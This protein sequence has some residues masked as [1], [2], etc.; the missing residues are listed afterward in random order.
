MFSRSF[1]DQMM[2]GVMDDADDDGDDSA[3]LLQA[4]TASKRRCTVQ[5]GRGDLTARR[6]TMSRLSLAPAERV[7]SR[8]VRQRKPRPSLLP[9]QPK[10][11]PAAA[12]V[13]AP[14][15]SS[16][17]APAP[18]TKKN[19]SP[20][21]ARPLEDDST[22]PGGPQV[23]EDTAE[24]AAGSMTAPTEPAS[25]S[26]AAAA[27]PPPV[28]AAPA[29]VSVSSESIDLLSLATNAVPD[30]GVEWD[31]LVNS[32]GIMDKDT[33]A[34]QLLRSGKIDIWVSKARQQRSAFVEKVSEAQ[35]KVDAQWRKVESM[36]L[37]CAEL[38]VLKSRCWSLERE[39]EQKQS[40]CASLREQKAGVQAQLA[41]AQAL[42]GAMRYRASG[43]PGRLFCPR[44]GC[45]MAWVGLGGVRRLLRPSHAVC[46]HDKKRRH[47]G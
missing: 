17:P 40:Q 18:T 4:S 6:T 32:C 34:E 7:N 33:I 10:Y 42:A 47:N 16:S 24:A 14:A 13:S 9:P 23:L 38:E 2:A 46:D 39:S 35:K 28:P 25:S 29:A 36:E 44:T 12:V 8:G 19:R 37:A 30:I 22:L 1:K 43:Y 27:A 45:L 5:G 21:A 20:T 11:A 3:S 15:Q 31:C 41:K 26:V